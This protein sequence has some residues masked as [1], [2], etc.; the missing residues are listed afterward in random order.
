V[1]ESSQFPEQQPPPGAM[2]PPPSAPPPPPPPPPSGYGTGGGY[3]QPAAYGAPT[4]GWG[5]P[6]LAEWP[7]RA[8]AYL[9]DWI[10]PFIV[11]AVVSV[12]IGAISDVLG[13]LIST[14]GYLAALGWALYNAYLAGQTGQSYGMQQFK[15]RL[16]KEADGQPIG[17]GM[18][19]ARAFINIVNSLPCYVGWLW[20]LWDPKKQTF[21]DKILA[22]VVIDEAA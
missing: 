21:T 11:V 2:P 13:F 19:I 7:K 6:P 15:I 22:T 10:G 18:G 5:G 20:P 12:I 3:G 17:G 16:L 4:P 8:G 9:I 14:V 1:S